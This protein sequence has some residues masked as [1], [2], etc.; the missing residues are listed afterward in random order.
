MVNKTVAWISLALARALGFFASLVRL[1]AVT[2]VTV[3]QVAV[4]QVTAT[5]ALPVSFGHNKTGFIPLSNPSFG[6]AHEPALL[7]GTQ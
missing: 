6:H 5:Q 7:E 3:T 4:T 2:Q 1:M